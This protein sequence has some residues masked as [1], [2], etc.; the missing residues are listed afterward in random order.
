MQTGRRLHLRNHSLK[1][2]LLPHVNE[3]TEKTEDVDDL[4][5]VSAMITIRDT[6]KKEHMR[7]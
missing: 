1:V 4:P 6:R 3:H 7:R 2:S 5:F